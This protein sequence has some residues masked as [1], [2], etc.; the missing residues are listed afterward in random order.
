[1]KQLQFVIPTSGEKVFFTTFVHLSL[2]CLVLFLVA[3]NMNLSDPFII[4]L[5]MNNTQKNIPVMLKDLPTVGLQKIGLTPQSTSS[6]SSLNSVSPTVLRLVPQTSAKN[7]SLQ[8]VQIS[9]ASPGVG[10]NNFSTIIGG[11][12]SLPSSSAGRPPGIT[13]TVPKFSI[14]Q[15]S[16]VLPMFYTNLHGNLSGVINA[17]TRTPTAVLSGN[18]GVYS[19]RSITPLATVALPS[20]RP[21]QITVQEITPKSSPVICVFDPNKGKLKNKNKIRFS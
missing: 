2:K 20:V 10:S 14:T 19:T 17:R 8:A 9:N 13:V 21:Q 11:S 7:S 16:S 12:Q 6:S 3:Q 1:M 15:R 5:K 18:V 4:Q